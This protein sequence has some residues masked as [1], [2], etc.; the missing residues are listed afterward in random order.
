MNLLS[1]LF[2]DPDAREISRAQLKVN[3]ANALEP[4]IAKLTDA[5]LKAQTVALRKQLTD[6]ARMTDILPEAFATVRE[7]ASRS[8]GQRH[9]D[10][11]LVGGVVLHEGKIAEMRTGEGKTLVA[12]APTY[13]NALESKGVHVV[14]VNDYLARR[15]A[16]WMAQVYHALGMTTGVIVPEATFGVAAYLYDPEYNDDSADDERLKHLRPVSRREAYAADITYG[17]NNEFGFDY[18]RDNMVSNAP[19]MVQRPLNYAIVDEVDSILIDEARTPLIISAPAE[20]STDKYVQFARLARQLKPEEDYVV[21]E[22]LKAVSITDEGI[23]KLEKALGVDNVYE[24]GMIEDVHHVEQSLKAEALF[25]RDRDYV[26]RDGEIIIVDEFTGRLMHGRRYSEGLHQAIEAKE[27]VEIRKESLTLATVTFQ[28]YFRLYQKL[29]GMT[30]TAATEAEEFS[31]IYELEVTTIP[32]HQPMVRIDHPDRIYRTE[33]GKFAAVVADVK[34]RHEKGQP[35]LLGTVSISKNEVLSDLLRAAGVPHEV[36]NAKNNQEEAGIVA[37]AGQKGAVT[38]ATNIAGRGTDIVLGEGVDK[39]GGLHV[40]GTERHESRRIDNQLRGRSGRQ[41]DPGSS[42]F[43]V[44]LEDDLMRI[45]GGERVAGLMQTLGLDDAVPLESSVVSRSLESAQKKVEGHNFDIRKQLVEYDDVMNKHREAIYGRRRRA[46]TSENL[47]PEIE[48]MLAAEFNDL[49]TAHTDT[50]TSLIEIDKVIE[51]VAAIIPLDDTI[52]KRL[53]AA[54]PRDV[55]TVLTEY[56]HQLYD[57]REVQFTPPHMRLMERLIY[58]QVLDR[59]WIEHLEAMD[60]LREGIGLR[61]IGQRDPLVEYKNEGFRLFKRLVSL[62]EAEIA[63]SILRAQITE[64]PAQQGVETAV[65]KA[66]AQSQVVS[67]TSQAGAATSG[68]SSADAAG[69]AGNRAARRAEKRAAKKQSKK[70]SR[71]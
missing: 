17:T 34:E 46:L 38:L 66:A 37:A 51:Q 29:A 25:E 26:V 33:M 44:S 59:L 43:Y 47:R 63:A 9:Y 61:A 3:Q 14:T 19:M 31:K 68:R 32:T 4:K 62:M 58:L 54:D 24:A 67:D 71:R 11:Q 39:L 55:T 13:L 70:A 57:A 27:G 36:L 5:K 35:V 52:T 7:A 16:G 2:G 45:F 42:R 22:K 41:G 12:T 30:G 8:I 20:E 53:K 64:E 49:V 23:T 69:D 6:G 56:A 10:V 40:V 15:D 48:P 50:R 28:N 21:D 65:T 18:L 60:R 1:R